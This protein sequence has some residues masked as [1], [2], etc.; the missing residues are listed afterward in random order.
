MRNC[1]SKLTGRMRDGADHVK[2]AAQLKATFANFRK[3][4]RT[5]D[6]ADEIITHVEECG[7]SFR[8]DYSKMTK[9]ADKLLGRF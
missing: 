4:C 8:L 1:A 7:A 3:N 5:E 9:A 6:H 2:T